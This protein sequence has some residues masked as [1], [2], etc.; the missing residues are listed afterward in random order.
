MFG[1]KKKLEKEIEERAEI[2]R[3]VEND[4]YIITKPSHIE[5]KIE[6]GFLR[7]KR[8]DPT[9]RIL[10]G[11]TGVKS[12]KIDG[13]AGINQQLPKKKANGFLQFTLSGNEHEKGLWGAIHDENSI[14]YNEV[15]VEIADKL[16]NRIESLIN[17]TQQSST[18]TSDLRALKD[19]LDDGIITQE[20]FDAKKKQILGL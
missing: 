19:L 7:I 1:K 3:Q 17:A 14:M 2:R 11:S 5:A 8:T 6:N 4:V 10:V 18:N 15:D 9:S 12:I 13:I 16:K 20:E